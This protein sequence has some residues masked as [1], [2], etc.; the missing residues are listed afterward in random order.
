MF[1]PD[2]A[3][4]RQVTVKF[5]PNMGDHHEPAKGTKFS[6][7]EFTA[8]AQRTPRKNFL[9]L[10]AQRLCGVMFF[11]RA[12]GASSDI[13]WPIQSPSVHCK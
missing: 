2:K 5:H 9:T 6:Q 8:E 3:Q 11:S 7:K 4:T 12:L 1:F 13:L 10:R